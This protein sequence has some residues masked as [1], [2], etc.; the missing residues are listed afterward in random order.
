MYDD[1]IKRTKELEK[2]KWLAE[3]A[4]QKREKQMETS[5]QNNLSSILKVNN[6]NNFSINKNEYAKV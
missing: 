5:R 2:K 6:F 4:E 3:L 1:E